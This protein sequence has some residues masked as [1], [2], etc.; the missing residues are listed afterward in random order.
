MDWIHNSLIQNSSSALSTQDSDE[1][2][3]HLLQ[4]LLVTVEKGIERIEWQSVTKPW[5][6]SHVFP[7]QLLNSTDS[8][9][10]EN[11]A[12]STKDRFV[13][14]SPE[15]ELDKESHDTDCRSQVA[16]ACDH[17]VTKTDDNHVEL[18]KYYN[19]SDISRLQMSSQ[20]QMTR[21]TTG[22]NRYSQTD[23]QL[24]SS[25]TPSPAVT[26]LYHREEE[27]DDGYH[28]NILSQPTKISEVDVKLL[29]SEIAVLPGSRDV[30]GRSVVVITLS[31]WQKYSEITA[32]QMALLLMYF[33]GIPKKEV[34]RR[35]FLVLLD[36]HHASNTELTELDEALY[37]LQ[38]NVNNAVSS[39]LIWTMEEGIDQSY[40]LKSQVKYEVIT[41]KENLH[42][43]IK[44]EQLLPQ[45]GGSY[46]YDH[47]EW[48]SFRK[49]IEPFINGCCICGRHLVRIMQELCTSRMPSSASLTSQ[50][51]EHHRRIIGSTFQGDYLRHLEEEGDTILKRIVSIQ[52]RM[53]H[54]V[55]Y[56]ETVDRGTTLYRELQ[57]AVR[58]L[59]KLVEK[60]QKKLETCLR[61]KTF[62]EESSQ[63]LGWL[64]WK[65]EETLSKHQAMADSFDA[66]KEQ[67]GEFEKFYFLAMRQI[68]KG[69]DL[70]EEASTFEPMS[71]S[72]V[73]GHPGV[74]TLASSL[75][76]HLYDFTERLD[77]TRERLE[78]STKCYSLL[79]RAYEWAVETMKFISHL[80]TE[81][82]TNSTELIKLTKSL[83]DYVDNNPPIS[84]EIFHEMISLATRLENESLLEQCRVSV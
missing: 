77:D 80:K 33:H 50:L 27:P 72:S 61:L 2:L 21:V 11:Q 68:E 35:G 40:F 83:Q 45:I 78:D 60:R 44:Q 73:G 46:F 67:E 43:F 34:I 62:E 75:A 1:D 14:T 79:D 28:D 38:A 69:N 70:M 58:K 25:T 13:Q 66:V 55:D 16:V 3:P 29:E 32:T 84:E 17:V 51:I 18:G 48:V 41:S 26:S 12:V 22:K 15:H 36:C 82:T 8:F 23:F 4:S 7:S 5:S 81:K 56:R 10:H 6:C 64:C 19:Q 9:Y 74:Q 24:D 31:I 39:V 42:K 63:V 30:T 53:P 49:S 71:K 57:C 52:K 37:L 76:K 54:N 20:D 65:G 59:T 47:Q